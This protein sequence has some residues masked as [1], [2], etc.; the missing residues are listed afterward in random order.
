MALYEDPELENDNEEGTSDP[1][2]GRGGIV[3]TIGKEAYREG[4]NEVIR[5]IFGFL[6][7]DDDD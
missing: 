1:S 3:R 7:G 2:F 5:S 6:F 4:K